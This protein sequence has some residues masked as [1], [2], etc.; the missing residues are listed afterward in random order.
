MSMRKMKYE[1][2]HR[3]SAKW[4]VAG[5]TIFFLLIVCFWQSGCHTVRAFGG[6]VEGVGTD[7][8]VAADGYTRQ[9][10]RE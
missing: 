2:E 7:I 4:F 10:A 3:E 1:V 5:L 9:F 6:L 8:Q